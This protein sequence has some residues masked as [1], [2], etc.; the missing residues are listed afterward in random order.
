MIWESRAFHS[1]AF[2]ISWYSLNFFIPR[3]FEW[4]VAGREHV[5]A[6]GAF[7]AASNHIALLDPPYAGASLTREIAF[8]AKKELFANPWLR[9]LIAAHNAL[10]IRRGGWDSSAFR[11]V[12]GMIRR[13]IPVM[14]FPEGTRSKTGDFLEPKAGIGMLAIKLGMPILPLYI[15]GTQRPLGD[16]L[17]RR[18]KLTS[19]IGPIIPA[20]IIR[21]YHDDKAGYQALSVHVMERI[22]GLRDGAQG[23]Q[24]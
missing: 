21:Q 18:A 10:P 17:R 16:L 7:L 4:R 11:R 9:S 19:R 20:D 24:R 15:D 22:A 13:G 23:A 2:R 6:S 1:R 14:V 5:P 3:L 12:E 8:L